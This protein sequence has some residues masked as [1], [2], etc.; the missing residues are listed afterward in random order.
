MTN[1]LVFLFGIEGNFAGLW[2]HSF[3]D[4][5]ESR[6]VD[7]SFYWGVDKV[8]PATCLRDCFSVQPP[9]RRSVDGVDSH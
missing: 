4:H 1:G 3:K 5:A 8:K 2:A 9:C 6:A 7:A